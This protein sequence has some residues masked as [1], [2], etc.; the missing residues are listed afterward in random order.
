MYIYFIDYNLEISIIALPWQEGA[1]FRELINLL[2]LFQQLNKKKS[3]FKK[4]SS[5]SREHTVICA[6]IYEGE[7]GGGGCNVIFTS[8]N[9][10]TKR[11]NNLN[12]NL[13][14]LQINLNMY[15]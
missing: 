11:L 9:Y 15:G 3:I 14:A 12:L 7:G 5:Q 10:F 6:Y 13:T 2:A 4:I 8:I 1:A